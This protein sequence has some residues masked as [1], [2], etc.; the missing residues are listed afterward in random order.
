MTEI[1]WEPGKVRPDGF[2]HTA[3]C[4]HY[5]LIVREYTKPPCSWDV[6]DDNIEGDLADGWS[7]N[8]D[9]EEAKKCAE[10]VVRVMLGETK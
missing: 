5:T 1:I 7:P 8:N 2:H 6:E 4:E 9:V 3:H 10:A